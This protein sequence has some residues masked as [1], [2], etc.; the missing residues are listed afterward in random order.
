MGRLPASYDGKDIVGRIPYTMSGVIFVANNTP[1]VQFP[2]STFQHNVDKPFEIHRAIPDLTAASTV[3]G[4]ITLIPPALNFGIEP[5]LR[6][7]VRMQIIDLARN[8]LM[9]KTPTM[10]EQ[11]IEK[12]TLAWNWEDP[13]IL[14]PNSNIIC[15][16]DNLAPA[17]FATGNYGP[18]T[19]AGG[20]APV[21]PSV[22]VDTIKIELVFQG[23]LLVT[24]RIPA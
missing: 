2:E 13:Y 8:E 22:A 7:Y 10:V 15:T 4:L 24:A 1:G 11:L 12:D 3:Q 18:S 5:F 20:A 14:R 9:V 19:G 21:V 23:F 17:T 16:I 6:K